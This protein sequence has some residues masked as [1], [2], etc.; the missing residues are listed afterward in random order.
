MTEFRFSPYVLAVAFLGIVSVWTGAQNAETNWP[1]AIVAGL[2][3]LILAYAYL[4]LVESAARL[5]SVWPAPPKLEVRDTLSDDELK[6]FGGDLPQS[7]FVVNEPRREPRILD[8]DEAT[9]YLRGELLAFLRRA[10]EIAGH[11]SKLVPR[12]DDFGPGWDKDTWM[13]LTDALVAAGVIVKI[14]RR[15]TRVIAHPSIG[16][17]LVAM[18]TLP[19]SASVRREIVAVTQAGQT[20]HEFARQIRPEGG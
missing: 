4:M 20:T 7:P 1:L 5:L 10:V 17:L 8:R 19:L 2:A 6:P 9:A 11:D 3:A 15:H 13:R 14:P 12:W 16:R 18:T